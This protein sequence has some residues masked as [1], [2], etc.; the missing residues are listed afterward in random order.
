[1]TSDGRDPGTDA[2]RPSIRTRLLAVIVRPTAPPL[3]LGVLVATAFI[4]AETVIIFVLREAVPGG[5]F[6]AVLLF[7]VLVVSAGWGFGLALVTTLAS[8]LVYVHFHIDDSA[9]FVPERVQD[10][11]AMFIFLPLALLASTLAGQARLRAAEAN[12]RRREA[13]LAA[14][15]ARLMLRAGAVRPA[16][17]RAAHRL[18]EVLGLP[19]AALELEAVPADEHRS[20]IPL[21]DG[22]SLLGTLLVPADLPV[23][24]QQRL[25]QR[26]VP[27]LEAQLAATRDRETINAALEESRKELEQFAEQQAALRRVAT[28][29]AHGVALTEVF[30]AVVG[31]LSRFT[32]VQDGVLLRNE[33]DGAPVVVA[34]SDDAGDAS[35]AGLRAEVEVPIVVGG[36][37]WGAGRV[38]SPPGEPLPTDIEARVQ[39]FT[40]LV[41]TAIT[42]VMTRAEL[43]ASRARIVAAGDAAR[44]RF[45]RDLHDGA[46]QRLVSLGLA[47]RA[48]EASVPPE[49]P[50]LREQLSDAVSG[51]VG[52]SGELQEIS[53]GIHP[54]IVSKGGVGPAIR[55]LARR[56]AVPV[57]LDVSVGRRLV[58]SA[59]VAVYYV[60]AEALT[61]AAK[62]ARASE[63]SVR[64]RAEA[65]NLCIAIRDDGTGGADPAQGSG[66]IGLRDRV[67]ALG[68]S[69]EIASPRGR[70]TALLVDIP[71]D[72]A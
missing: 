53:R 21:R 31:E 25:H 41:A 55:T 65:T 15:L 17:D 38:G 50:A 33:P 32:G 61:N 1:M 70:G 37:I 19:F 47:L 10:L 72:Q 58:D 52:V 24:V 16:L 14:E 67:E 2:E 28:L 13:D 57:S 40:D 69:M 26:V 30:S 54:A 45:E 39:D 42:N 51:L 63:V 62:H 4:V 60:V 43:T 9:S 11:T 7:G 8:A 18:A 3:A 23:S 59:E 71:L 49:Q 46:Q 5:S 66:L 64:I 20:A 27:S 22:A 44:R 34:A 12:Q 29:V 48:I 56:S 68:G 6:G 36:R 35:A